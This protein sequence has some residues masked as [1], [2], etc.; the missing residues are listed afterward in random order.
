ME[1]VV[2]VKV[3]GQLKLLSFHPR[4]NCGLGLLG[5][6]GWEVLEGF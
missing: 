1:R 2:A 4:G 6:R 3:G 5:L